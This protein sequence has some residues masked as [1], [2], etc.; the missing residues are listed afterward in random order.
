MSILYKY[1]HRN[2]IK[3]QNG[4]ATKEEVDRLRNISGIGPVEDSQTFVEPEY[5]SEEELAESSEYASK[6]RDK[7]QYE[8]IKL[9]SD[10]F[11]LG[12]LND[13]EKI[14]Y[15]KIVYNPYTSAT[16]KAKQLMVLGAKYV[17][18]ASLNVGLTM[19]GGV[20]GR[21]FA[22]KLLNTIKASVN[23][24][25]GMFDFES[26]FNRGI[27]KAAVDNSEEAIK[28]TLNKAY[29]KTRENVLDPA[30]LKRIEAADGRGVREYVERMSPP[31]MKYEPMPGKDYLGT[32]NARK[33]LITINSNK[34]PLDEV[35]SF[36][37]TMAHETSHIGN[38]G[39]NLLS[40][41]TIKFYK[42]RIPKWE[43][44][45]FNNNSWVKKYGLRE[46]KELF[47][48]YTKPTE[49]RAYLGTNAKD[50]LMLFGYI[51]DITDKITPEMVK[52]AASIS[53]TI[54]TYLKE[55]KMTP[56][57]IAEIMNR[58]P[59]GAAVPLMLIPRLNE[60]DKK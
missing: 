24:V 42:E 18:S 26:A 23:P 7:D 39:G 15:N 50:E 35:G 41:A 49:M 27:Q 53:D 58:E 14:E 33:N 40:D 17:P 6:V 12:K 38:K 45:M 11:S 31:N 43:N 2:V 52:K 5:R 20:G 25:H 16:T 57:A 29:Y 60:N 30:N 19:L 59:Y 51:D 55:L 22:G 9:L 44:I 1:R 21:T 3:A 37:T 48:Y 46:A 34:I 28:K 54:G 56:K 36:Y 32:A 4:F 10:P 8:F 13:E 47:K